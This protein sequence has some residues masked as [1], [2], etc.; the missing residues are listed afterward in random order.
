MT[1]IYFY[2]FPP[3]C[4]DWLNH[5]NAFHHF[6]EGYLKCRKFFEMIR[7]VAS[8]QDKQE[9]SL[10][11]RTVCPASPGLL[12]TWRRE[13]GGPGGWGWRAL[14]PGV[15]T[16]LVVLVRFPSPDP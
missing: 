7:W 3:N 15:A 8:C 16:F 12:D 9:G 14:P 2:R 13:A 10:I 1:V 5:T 11:V 4:K 6:L